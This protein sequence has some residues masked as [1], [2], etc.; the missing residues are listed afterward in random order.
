MA[1]IP[2]GRLEVPLGRWSAGA[3]AAG[4]VNQRLVA[5]RV[6]SVRLAHGAQF[7]LDTATVSVLADAAGVRSIE[8]WNGPVG[9]PPAAQ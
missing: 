8:R 9:D 5:A 3:L 1:Y 7:Q 4:A 6:V 2:P